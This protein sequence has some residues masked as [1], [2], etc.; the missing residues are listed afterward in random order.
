MA[1]VCWKRPCHTFFLL[2]RPQVPTVQSLISSRPDHSRSDYSAG[3]RALLDHPG[4][5]AVTFAVCESNLRWSSRDSRSEQRSRP[6]RRRSGRR[7]NAI[8]GR[9]AFANTAAFFPVSS[10]PGSGK[11]ST[12]LRGRCAFAN[13]AALFP[14]FSRPGLGRP[15]SPGSPDST[16]GSP[17]SSLAPRLSRCQGRHCC[18][19]EGRQEA[20]EEGRK[21]EGSG[22]RR[23]KAAR[24]SSD[25]S[26]R[27]YS[28]PSHVCSCGGSWYAFC[29]PW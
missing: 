21:G 18:A 9:G 28:G 11:L 27:D 1:P 23:C 5:F 2:L 8:A 26:G 3:D 12:G 29:L 7:A 16:A 25:D 10:R 20:E 13:S 14:G 15:D 17:D 6:W 19:A 24:G 22:E 4:H